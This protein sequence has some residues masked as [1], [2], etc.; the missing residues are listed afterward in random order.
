MGAGVVA[1]EPWALSGAP[2]GYALF[3]A[4]RAPHRH[5]DPP[6]ALVNADDVP[7]VAPILEDHRKTR[8]RILLPLRHVRDLSGLLNVVATDEINR[9]QPA[10][11]RRHV[12]GNDHETV[13]LAVP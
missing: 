5:P 13:Q 8:P 3:D 12:R 1:D 9:K 2:H 11:E 10:D 6:Q 4:P 7:V